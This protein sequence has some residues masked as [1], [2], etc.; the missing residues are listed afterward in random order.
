MVSQP[1]KGIM[2]LVDI[3]FDM[4]FQ[5][6]RDEMNRPDLDVVRV[7]RVDRE[8]YLVRNEKE[9]VQAE[10][11]GKLLFSAASGQDLP[12]VGDWALVQYYNERTLAIIH[13][14]LP[15][16]TFL[17]RKAAGPKVDYQMIAA[18]IDTAFI[19][20]S[21]DANFN[22][23]RMERYLVMVREGHISPAI[24]LSKCDLVDQQGLR[25]R[26]D[27][28]V[29]SHIDAPVVGFSNATGDG[30]PA[31]RQ[32]LERAHTYCLIGS[33]GVGKTTLVNQLLGRDEFETF[34]V[35]EQD[36]RGRH[37]TARRQLT[38]LEGGALFIDTPGMR[39]LG[40]IDAGASIDASFSEITELS[41]Q[42][43]FADCTH[44]VE[45]G[46]AIRHAVDNGELSED[47]YRSYVKLVKESAF[48]QQSY[49]ERR[50]KDKQ[51]GRMINLAKKQM[52][53][54]KPSP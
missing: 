15:R 12:C 51:F 48:H 46:C 28:I 52:H 2:G 27:E 14:L 33:S 11:T 8:R 22:I 32:M 10:P 23:R 20:Q 49:A 44:M 16:R 6:K 42:C 25:D 31:I 50:E 39:E 30:L 35:R 38:M 9:E 36:R 1:E 29:R 4:W 47:R 19:V 21:C 41:G 53:K 13:D 54:R 40:V 37:T 24:L 18:N 45:T 43:R 17:R 26:F 34:P 7:T 5:Q 3:G